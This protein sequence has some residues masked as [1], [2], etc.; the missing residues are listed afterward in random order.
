LYGPLPSAGLAG[1]LTTGASGASN[2]VSGLEPGA[3]TVTET[4]APA[5]YGLAAPFD[6]T[7]ALGH[8]VTT[9]SV[10]DA[11]DPGSLDVYN[12]VAGSSAPV[13]GGVF[14]VRYDALDSGTYSVDLGRC[15]TDAIGAC[16]PA[17]GGGLGLLPGRYEVTQVSAPP[18]YGLDA[19]TAVRQTV[20]AHGA[21]DVVDFDDP[22]L[23]SLTFTKVPTANFDP[24]SLDL[25]CARFVV[26]AT[27]AA[28]PVVA[29]CTT[30][31]SG[32][33]ETARLLLP[34]ER[35]CWT[36]AVAPPG[37]AAGVG[38]C[39]DAVAGEPTT[40]LAAMAKL[41][42]SETAVFCTWAAVQTLGGWGYSRDHPVEQWLRDAKLEEIEEGTSDIMRLVIAR[43]LA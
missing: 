23:V 21:V 37:F 35:Y 9:A 41:T 12:V 42:A 26:R 10:E 14:D 1:V 38:G 31:V 15:T 7:V 39:L 6:V 28:G 29:S 24:S 5:G 19:S 16:S 33:C 17:T 30:G 22:P 11:V 18:G 20:L 34:G 43:G 40:S 4:T 27:T 8:S 25:G 36:E 32:S 3:Y 2:V 13:V